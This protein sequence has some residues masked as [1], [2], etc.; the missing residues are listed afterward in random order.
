MTW[1]VTWHMYVM[2]VNYPGEE[3]VVFAQ[4][5][6]ATAATCGSTIQA[7]SSSMAP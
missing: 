7:G 5:A 4:P 1:R 6:A 3:V 2:A